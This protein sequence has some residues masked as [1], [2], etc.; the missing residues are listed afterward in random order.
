MRKW[1]LLLIFV[2]ATL[3][4]CKPSDRT[5]E[6]DN[7]I[8]R[9]KMVDIMADVEVV[10][11]QLRFQQNR[12]NHDSLQKVKTKSYD[13]LYMYFKVTPEQFSQSIKFYQGDLVNFE[14]M[15]DEVILSI[16]RARDSVLNIKE[17]AKDSTAVAAD[18]TVVKRADN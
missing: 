7:L 16:T 17:I 11:A 14:G 9:D 8:P 2:L 5:P 6:P 18:S 15:I 13:S 12:I 1:P 3:W 10:E 4:G